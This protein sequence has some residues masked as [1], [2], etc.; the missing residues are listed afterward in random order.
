LG[1]G[2]PLLNTQ[3]TDVMKISRL[4]FPTA[5]INITTNGLLLKN[6][7]K[8]FWECCRTNNIDIIISV[9]PVRIDYPLLMDTAKKYG[10]QLQFRGNVKL[11]SKNW[12]E[13]PVEYISARWR[14]LPIDLEGRQN[15]QKS[16]ALCYASNYCFQLVEGRLYKCWRSAYAKDFNS[17]F[18]KQ[19]EVTEDDYIDIYKAASI[20]EILEK[21]RKPAPFCR[22]CKM[23]G[24][25][26]VKW[27]KSKREITEWT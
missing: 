9:Y 4:Y 3:I 21:L 2:E 10:V 22:Y 16:N 15:P 13:L 27:R 11:V 26:T 8:E 20:D 17:Y 23:D 19:L 5:A 1:G 7:T 12:K 25:K 24:G 6:Q 14:Q 18:N